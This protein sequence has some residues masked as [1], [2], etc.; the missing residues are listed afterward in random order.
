M[1]LRRW[2]CPGRLRGW[3]GPRCGAVRC[4]TVWSGVGADARCVCSCTW[5][6]A[7][8]PM[9]LPTTTKCLSACMPRHAAHCCGT[10]WGQTLAV[11]TVP[12]SSGLLQCSW[13][14]FHSQMSVYLYTNPCI[15]VNDVVSRWAGPCKSS[16]VLVCLAACRTGELCALLEKGLSVPDP[17]VSTGYSEDAHDVCWLNFGLL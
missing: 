13:L 16:S 3:C 8:M 7:A 9:G 5:G 12:A 10:V 14:H 2:R 11:C 4:G 17:R 6:A 15:A 1:R